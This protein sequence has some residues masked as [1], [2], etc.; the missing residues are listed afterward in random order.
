ML[1]K[2]INRYCQF[3]NYLLVAALALMVVLVFTNVV[4][5]YAANSGISVSEELSRW[6]FVWLTFLGAIVALNEGAHL[7]TDTLVSRL[8][9]RGKKV[10]LVLAH[11]LMLFVCWLIFKGSLDQVKINWDSTSAAMEVS[12]ALFY[13]CGMVFAVSGAVIL[14]NHLW[15]LF[16]GQLSEAELIGIRESEEEPIDV[17]KPLK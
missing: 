9:V 16:T 6:L 13:G 2:L 10:C 4:L 7:G 5:R 1:Q 11:V 8:S 12:M 15:R 3:L 17:P 14:L